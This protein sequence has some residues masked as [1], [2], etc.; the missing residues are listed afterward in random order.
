MIRSATAIIDDRFE[1]SRLYI[2]F[3]RHRHSF[4]I[5]RTV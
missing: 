2:E 4:L 1:D 3:G 5:E